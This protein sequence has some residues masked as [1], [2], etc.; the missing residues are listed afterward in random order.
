M[1]ANGRWDLIRRLKI[2]E[3]GTVLDRSKWTVEPNLLYTQYDRCHC[4]RES[5][6]TNWHFSITLIKDFSVLFL[7]CQGLTLKYGAWPALFPAK[8]SKISPRFSLG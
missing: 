2:K 4:H 1:P 7:Q 3:E 6:L 8:A 5:D